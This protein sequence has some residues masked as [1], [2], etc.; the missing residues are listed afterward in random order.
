MKPWKVEHRSAG[1]GTASKL[2]D[3]TTHYTKSEASLVAQQ[4]T[5]KK[6]G[7]S[8]AIIRRKDGKVV[9]RYW[10]DQVGGLQHLEY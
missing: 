9:M 3:T 7:N 1:S 2:V 4:F 6:V 5:L 8:A 10:Y